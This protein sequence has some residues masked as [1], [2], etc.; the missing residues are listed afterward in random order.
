MQ[1]CFLHKTVLVVTSYLTRTC[2]L[3]KYHFPD[4]LILIDRDACFKIE[5]KPVSV[6]RE[7]GATRPRFLIL[8]G[9]FHFAVYLQ[10]KQ[11]PVYDGQ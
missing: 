1:S 5:Y 4:I 11:D 3:G 9:A 10:Q 2:L 7:P 6:L 8:D